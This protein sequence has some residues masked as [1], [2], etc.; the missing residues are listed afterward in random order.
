[1]KEIDC[2][3]LIKE[4]KLKLGTAAYLKKLDIKEIFLSK[5]KEID[6]HNSQ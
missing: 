4:W 1:M 3:A 5:K 2:L 6:W